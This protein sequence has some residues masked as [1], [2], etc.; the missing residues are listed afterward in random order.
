MSKRR[1]FTLLE[2]AT[3]LF[4]IMVGLFGAIH[5]YQVGLAKARAL[6]ETQSALGAI[7]NEIETLR[8]LP[9]DRIE[10][11]DA[12]RSASPELERLMNARPTVKV[13]DYPGSEGRLKEVT[14]GVRW[15][16]EHGRTI[17]KSVTTL[18]ADK[19]F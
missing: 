17:D 6:D 9:F 1:G 4:V 3:A 15:S 5:L 8:A 2:M 19:G 7:Q 14:V 11:G 18:I 13:R 12:F 10:T 16:G